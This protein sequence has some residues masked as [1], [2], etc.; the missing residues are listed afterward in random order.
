[1]DKESRVEIKEISTIVLNVDSISWYVY[2]LVPWPWSSLYSVDFYLSVLHLLLPA[3]LVCDVTDP[4][5]WAVGSGDSKLH[6][7]Q[8]M[9]SH[10]VRLVAVKPLLYC[11]C[12][13]LLLWLHFSWL[14]CYG[15]P[16]GG[17]QEPFLWNP[18]WYFFC[19]FLLVQ[20]AWKKQNKTLV[21]GWLVAATMDAAAKA[22]SVWWQRKSW[23][24]SPTRFIGVFVDRVISRNED[25]TG[26]MMKYSMSHRISDCIQPYFPTWFL[27]CHLT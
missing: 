8:L 10:R 25:V 21:Y 22:C 5:L 2:C 4:V 19:R 14:A 16:G 12:F 17:F 13:C 9:L 23:L 26:G 6:S 20:F 24:W 1:M 11:L 18:Y 7:K 27:V 3:P 15:G